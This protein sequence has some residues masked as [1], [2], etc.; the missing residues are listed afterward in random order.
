[1]KEKTNRNI[2]NIQ[3]KEQDCKNEYCEQDLRRQEGEQLKKY[4]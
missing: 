4:K 2:D 3:N 1:M